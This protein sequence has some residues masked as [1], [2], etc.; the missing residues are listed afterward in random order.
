VDQAVRPT[1]LFRGKPRRHDDENDKRHVP[2]DRAP[3]Y[4]PW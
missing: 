3:G 2:L 1:R 4:E